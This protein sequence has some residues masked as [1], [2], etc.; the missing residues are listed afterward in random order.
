M[1]PIPVS[2]L[3]LVCMFSHRRMVHYT[4]PSCSVVWDAEFLMGRR[5]AIRDRSAQAATETSRGMAQLIAPLWVLY[6]RT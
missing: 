6:Y 1:L 5:L 2:R 4:L 3:A